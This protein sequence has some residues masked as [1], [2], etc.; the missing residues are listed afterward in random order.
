M[1]VKYALKQVIVLQMGHA[2]YY[3]IINNSKGN[4]V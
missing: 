2:Q 3:F 4:I 1:K